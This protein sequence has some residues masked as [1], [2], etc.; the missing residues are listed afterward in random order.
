[1]N[2][3][4]PLI[5]FLGNKNA[6]CFYKNNRSMTYHNN[7]KKKNLDIK[8]DKEVMTSYKSGNVWQLLCVNKCQAER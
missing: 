3:P 1:M 2:I 5:A 8:W 4:F 7:N 6:L